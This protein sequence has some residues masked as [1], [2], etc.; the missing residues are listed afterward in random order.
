MLCVNMRLR[1][2]LRLRYRGNCDFSVDVSQAGASNLDL[3]D[4]TEEAANGR[5]RSTRQS[6]AVPRRR[7]PTLAAER[8]LPLLR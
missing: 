4:S 1:L 2:R 5:A 6:I 7:W 8:V 3:A